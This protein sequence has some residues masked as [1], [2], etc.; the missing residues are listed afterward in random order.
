MAPLLEL[1]EKSDWRQHD[2]AKKHGN[3]QNYSKR[4]DFTGDILVITY[5]GTK[6]MTKQSISVP[7]FKAK[8]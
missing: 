2:H 7:T 8:M 1:F 3:A 5:E 6:S 4:M